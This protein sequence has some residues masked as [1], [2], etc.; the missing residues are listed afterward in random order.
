MKKE[1]EDFALHVE[2]VMNQIHDE[3]EISGERVDKYV[4]ISLDGKEIKFPLAW[5][6]MELFQHLLRVEKEN[7]E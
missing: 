5:D 1:L 3:H 4:T 2:L 7:Y 6:T